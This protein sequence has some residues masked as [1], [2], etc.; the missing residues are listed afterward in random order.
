MLETGKTRMFYMNP[1]LPLFAL[2]VF[3][4][5]AGVGYYNRVQA[6]NQQI[7]CAALHAEGVNINKLFAADPV[8]Y[9]RLDRNHNGIPCE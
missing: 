2:A 5:V 1:V 6:E 3:F 4:G 7:S 9:K 8:K